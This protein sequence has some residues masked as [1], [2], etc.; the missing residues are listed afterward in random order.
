MAFPA[1]PLFL[2]EIA[3]FM[4]WVLLGCVYEALSM[5]R[6]YLTSSAHSLQ[7]LETLGVGGGGWGME[8]GLLNAVSG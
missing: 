2:E 3:F 5:T 8:T 1:Q 6:G 4:T 7:V